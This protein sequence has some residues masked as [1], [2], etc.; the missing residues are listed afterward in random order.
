VTVATLQFSRES[1]PITT[2]RQRFSEPSTL[3]DERVGIGPHH[4]AIGKTRKLFEKDGTI[5]AFFS[6]GYEIAC[7]TLDA[8]SLRLRD[9]QVLDL[10]IAWGGGAFC[11]DCDTEGRVALVFVHRN[12]HELCLATGAIGD[13]HIEW[14]PWR[15]LLVSSA[16]QAAP[17]LELGSHGTGWC[18]VL[19]RTGDFRIAAVKGKTVRV[20]NLFGANEQ[21]WYHSCVQVLPVA[22]DRAVAIGF[23]GSFPSKTE[24]VFKTV[25][26]A[27]EMGPSET[28]APCNVNDRLTFHFQAVGDPA[29]EC[30]HIVYLDEGLSVSHAQY[31]GGR[32][33]VAKRI[34]PVAS[35]APQ[36]CINGDGDLLLLA[37]DYE[38]QIWKA[39]RPFRGEWSEPSIVPNLTGPNVS[40]LF[41]QTGYG[42]GGLISAA[43]SED[44]RVPFLLAEIKDERTSTAALRIA[45]IGGLPGILAT[46]GALTITQTGPTLDVDIRL[47]AL[48]RSDLKEK[49]NSWLVVIP[50]QKSRALKVRLAGGDAVTASAAWLE[51]DGQHSPMKAHATIRTSLCDAFSPEEHGAIRT[52]LAMDAEPMDL[53]LDRAWVETYCGERLVDMAPFQPEMAARLAL[54]P[55]LITRTYKRMV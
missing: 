35:F 43:R 21:A 32:W 25:S 6:R 5:F 33:I 36:I 11:V 9:T 30:A 40:A 27:L 1:H 4:L 51:A 28:L 42:T 22:E 31:S 55:D 49:T 12:Q 23:R 13:G 45:A 14:T 20:G 19:D 24:L 54:N 47:A 15:S 7:A 44:G 50:A 53:R 34:I 8:N 3:V 46:E 17:W 39:T 29:R 48:S 37:A 52:V 26:A 10:P 16:S 2:F 38:G 18:S 41:A